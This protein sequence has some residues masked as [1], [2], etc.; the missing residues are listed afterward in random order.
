MPSCPTCGYMG[1]CASQDAAFSATSRKRLSVISSRSC[2][3]RRTSCSSGCSRTR[4]WQVRAERT[5]TNSSSARKRTVSVASAEVGIQSAQEGALDHFA[6]R[7]RR[8]HTKR[9]RAEERLGRSSQRAGAAGQPEVPFTERQVGVGD[10][11]VAPAGLG[12]SDGQGGKSHGNSRDCPVL[13]ASS[14]TCP[15]TPKGK[16]SGKNKNAPSKNFLSFESICQTLPSRLQ[17]APRDSLAIP[18]EPVQK[19]PQS[20]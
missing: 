3:P 18:T 10:K 5:S 12:K 4:L 7:S 6:H 9:Q 8:A 2:W 14:S 1:R 13:L 11:D 17:D 16:G 20:A 19:T 15:K